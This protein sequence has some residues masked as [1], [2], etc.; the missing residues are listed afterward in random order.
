V[1]KAAS[2]G[3]LRR[4]VQTLVIFVLL[5]AST[6]AAVL[7]L[8]LLT[9][10]NEL[11]LHAVAAQR[12]ADVAGFVDSARATDAQLA[13]STRLAGVTRAGPYPEVTVTAQAANAG[14]RSSQGG[15]LSCRG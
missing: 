7:G 2:G 5:T 6:A 1:I 4:R 14:R 3:L 11:F 12:G 15:A 8:T 9:N 10:A 13:A